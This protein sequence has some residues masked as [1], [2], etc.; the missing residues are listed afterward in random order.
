MYFQRTRISLVAFLLV[1]L[2]YFLPG[3]SLLG[4]EFFLVNELQLDIFTILSAFILCLG[5]VSSVFYIDLEIENSLRIKFAGIII[6]NINIVDID[7]IYE[8]EAKGILAFLEY[9]P[10]MQTVED[11]VVISTGS[12]FVCISTEKENYYVSCKDAKS[13]CSYFHEIKNG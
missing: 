3:L 5:L 7:D 6:K 9:I 1:I 10:S 13:I 2:L 8:V 12:G 4:I 11:G